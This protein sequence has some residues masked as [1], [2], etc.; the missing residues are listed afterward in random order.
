IASYV[1]LSLGG[2]ARQVRAGMTYVVV[3]LV[4]SVLFVTAVGLT[5]AAT[6]TVN[7]AQL[8]GRIAD[9]PPEVR[10]G[11]ALLFLAVF[12]IKAALFPLFFWLPE[13]YP[14]APAPVT[15]LF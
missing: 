7:L 12:G 10:T 5:Y 13:S 8:A 6:G 1:L 11:L 9:L 15:A 4:A 3:S 14:A 2:S